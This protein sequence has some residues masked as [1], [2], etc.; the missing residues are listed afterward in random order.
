[1]AQN[2][3]A[4]KLGRMAM[5]G[6]ERLEIA[7]R[8]AP[9]TLESLVS[10]RVDFLTAY[11]NA[12]YAARFARQVEAM[13]QAEAP[14]GSTRL[15]EAVARS[16]FK[17]MAYKDE[18]EVA[19]LHTKSGFTEQIARDFEGDFTLRYHL[20]PPLLPGGTDARGRPRKRA[21][22]GWM[23]GAFRLL[24]P[25]KR[26]RGT[27]FDPFGHTPE[28]RMERALIGWYEARIAEWIRA[29]PERG[30]AALVPLAEAPMDLRGYGPVKEEACRRLERFCRDN[31]VVPPTVP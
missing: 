8:P 21:F 2:R 29:L 7:E 5:A 9:E 24:A 3:E 12:A 27:L 22:G 25:M 30:V 26:L 10:R 19:R 6:P 18:Y 14:F 15:T 31:G 13:R 16:L 20:A 11:Q 28:R 23:Q 4:F 1:V 17:L